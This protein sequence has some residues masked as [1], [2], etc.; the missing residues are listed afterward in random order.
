MWRSAIRRLC[1]DGRFVIEYYVPKALAKR[2]LQEQRAGTELRSE[3]RRLTVMFT[4]IVGFTTL[5]EA[6]P[7]SDIADLLKRAFEILGGH[8]QRRRYR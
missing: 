2:I 4:D 5:S 8:V 7:A 1:F 6:M 3:Q